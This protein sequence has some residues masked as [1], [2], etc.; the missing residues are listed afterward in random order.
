MHSVLTHILNFSDAKITGQ[1]KWIGHCPSHRSKRHRDL[2]IR[3]VADRILIHCFGGCSLENI[4][5]A[6]GIRKA[7]LFFDSDFDPHQIALHRRARAQQRAAR[8]DEQH[9]MGL[10]LDATREAESLIVSARNVSIACWTDAQ[11]HR[12]LN[13]LADAYAITESEET[14]GV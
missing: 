14:H 11:L 6:L 8:A 13:R 7:D 2:S 3:A 12:A 4:C 1:D 5:A 9:R 10:R